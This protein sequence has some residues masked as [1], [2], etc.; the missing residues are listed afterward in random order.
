MSKG[1]EKSKVVAG[2]V[3]G[4]ALG[5]AAAGGIAWYLL[6]KNPAEFS[7][8]E[9]LRKELAQVAPAP[10]SA[11]PATTKSAPAPTPAEKKPQFEFYKVLTD[12]GD[13]TSAKNTDRQLT[14]PK[15]TTSTSATSV[16]PAQ[17]AAGSNL[18]YFVQAGS[19]QNKDDAEKLK[20]KLAFSG[21]ESGI[22]TA[23]VAGKGTVYRV[24]L[25]PYPEADAEKTIVALKQNG[26]TP[27]R[28][29]AQ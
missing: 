1:G 11:V 9:T 26:I 7:S 27:M 17:T 8:K 16:P 13:G 10:A 21:L 2:V 4:M 25:G 14:K 6:K 19:F 22:Q 15:D 28:V 23:D 20:A 24:R 5:L 18:R 29:R 3:I 12:K